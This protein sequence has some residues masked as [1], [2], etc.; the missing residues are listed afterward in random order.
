MT[1][2]YW[3]RRRPPAYPDES[4]ER[5]PFGIPANVSRHRARL[6][7]GKRI[8]DWLADSACM[9]EPD[10]AGESLVNAVESWLAVQGETGEPWRPRNREIRSAERGLQDAQQARQRGGRGLWW[11]VESRSIERPALG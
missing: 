1:A 3:E 5:R 11:L 6:E 10:L 8:L 2:A 4:A 7:A 9:P